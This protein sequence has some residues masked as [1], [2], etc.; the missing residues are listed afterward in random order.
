MTKLVYR[1]IIKLVSAFSRL[2]QTAAQLV[3]LYQ[4]R[5]QPDA[6]STLAPDAF[7]YSHNKLSG[8]HGKLHQR[9]SIKNSLGKAAPHRPSSKDE[10]NFV[11][12]G[13]STDSQSDD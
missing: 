10:R 6:L 3:E 1:V 4:L 7:K 11:I 2:A 12:R 8:T 5:T 9:S 13:I